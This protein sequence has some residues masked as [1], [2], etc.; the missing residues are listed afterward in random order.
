MEVYRRG[1]GADV[2]IPFAFELVALA[3]TKNKDKTQNEEDFLERAFT[4]LKEASGHAIYA[5]QIVVVEMITPRF[6]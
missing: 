3:M 5:G 4:F 6:A 2:K 1:R